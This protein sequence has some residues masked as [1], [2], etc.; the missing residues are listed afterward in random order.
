[1]CMKTLL[2]ILEKVIITKNGVTA[3]LHY[4]DY[5]KTEL[6]LYLSSFPVHTMF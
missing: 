3:I 6:D 4:T 5:S 1:M 2:R